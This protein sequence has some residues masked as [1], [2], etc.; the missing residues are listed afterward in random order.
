MYSGG[1]SFYITTLTAP[2]VI[3]KKHVSQ[4]REEPDGWVVYL[5]CHAAGI[6]PPVIEW[7]RNGNV[8]CTLFGLTVLTPRNLIREDSQNA[9]ATDHKSAVSSAIVS[10]TLGLEV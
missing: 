9:L 6:P 3:I 4:M 2:A 5:S 7:R 10:V 8:V 1:Y